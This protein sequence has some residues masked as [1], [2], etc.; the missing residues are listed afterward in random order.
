VENWANLQRFAAMT[1]DEQTAQGKRCPMRELFA[2]SDR[3]VTLLLRF[4]VSN[5]RSI[6]RAQSLTLAVSSDASHASDQCVVC[7]QKMELLGREAR[8][9]E[10]NALAGELKREHD[11]AVSRMREIVEDGQ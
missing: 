10:A 6:G 2:G 11:R 9:D 5:F 7:Y 8:M 4:T 3:G 1:G